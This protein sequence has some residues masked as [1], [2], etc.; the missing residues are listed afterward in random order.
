MNKTTLEFTCELA[1]RT[2]AI[3]GCNINLNSDTSTTLY[4]FSSIVNG[5]DKAISSR[6]A[7]ILVN[8]IEPTAEYNFSA[9]PHAE[10]S[11]V[12][13][14]FNSKTGVIPAE[15]QGTALILQNSY[16]HSYKS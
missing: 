14:S 7:V 6:F 2:P 5:S 11:G 15:L 13:I 1:C 10:K 4:N 8:G 16:V 3:T 12:L 9:T